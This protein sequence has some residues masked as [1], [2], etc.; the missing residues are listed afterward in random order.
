MVLMRPHKIVEY[1]QQEVEAHPGDKKVLYNFRN[2]CIKYNRPDLAGFQIGDSVTVLVSTEG[3][4][5][6][7]WNGTITDLNEDQARVFPRNNMIVLKDPAAMQVILQENGLWVPR[8]K[9][10][11]QAPV[12]P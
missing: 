10:V 1:A 11:L 3:I 8:G 9:L 2:V 6:D 12:S 7:N 5:C 4:W